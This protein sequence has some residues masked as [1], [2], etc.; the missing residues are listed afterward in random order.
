MAF[1]IILGDKMASKTLIIAGA[2]AGKTRTAIKY[3]EMNI[4]KR[5][6]VLT[7]SREAQKTFAS[8]FK[9]EAD[10]RTIDS[11]TRKIITK[12]GESRL[13]ITGGQRTRRYGLNSKDKEKAFD[14]TQIDLQ[15]C[16][17]NNL[18][19]EY[20]RCLAND[21]YIDHN[22]TL[23]RVLLLPVD[24]IRKYCN[25]DVIIVDE[26]QDINPA[27]WAFILLIS[28]N[29]DLFCVGDPR[30]NIYTF[31]GADSSIIES[32]ANEAEKIQLTYN[33]RSKQEILNVGNV[34]SYQLD[35][36]L[37]PL[38]ACRG[39]GGKGTVRFIQRHEITK[40]LVDC[41]LNDT[42]IISFTNKTV[43]QIGYEIGKK[44]FEYKTIK[45]MYEQELVRTAIQII[46][47]LH[48]MN[49]DVLRK[50]ILDRL[51]GVGEKAILALTDHYRNDSLFSCL[52]QLAYEMA[53]VYDHN[54][55]K[56]KIVDSKK[57]TD[58]K[59]QTL[60]NFARKLSENLDLSENKIEKIYNIWRYLELDD[61]VNFYMFIEELKGTH[62]II[63]YIND[64][65]SG[66]L[67]KEKENGVRVQT[68][69][70]IKGDEKSVIF[71]IA[72][73]F[74]QSP[75]EEVLRMSY[76]AVTRARDRLFIVGND[77]YFD[78]QLYDSFESLRPQV[79]KAFE[80]NKQN[81]ANAIPFDA[82]FSTNEDFAKTWCD[83]TRN[84]PVYYE[85]VIVFQSKFAQYNNVGFPDFPV[86]PKLVINEEIE[87]EQNNIRA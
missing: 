54:G 4:G 22:I 13:L 41:D 34:Y 30:Q 66:R 50:L 69:H 24:V 44:G 26:F 18:N 82:I 2:G 63:E 12:Q 65:D 25:Y 16:Q 72:D 17:P 83:Y 39:Y 27:Q 71:F 19:E 5:I 31:R 43:N 85:D 53:Q 35:K 42:A 60:A 21:G 58:T 79:E 46:K 8:R 70:S 3:A 11:L 47:V 80:E 56:F 67:S 7:F 78:K 45:P 10:I 40:Y 62:D 29:A 86:L 61:D 14:L 9:G 33:Y 49:E 76:V 36:T 75:P 20:A 59:K 37:D 23:Q 48:L 81:I 87:D 77:S 15:H 32:F 52:C 57:I 38:I 51:G 55:N 68:I 1:S 64:I 28:G 6:L 74:G 84:L 73:D